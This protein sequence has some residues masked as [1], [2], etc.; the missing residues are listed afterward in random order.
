MQIIKYF[1]TELLKVAVFIFLYVCSVVYVMNTSG[2]GVGK[3]VK[4]LSENIKF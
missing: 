4:Y 3:I 2:A 1:K